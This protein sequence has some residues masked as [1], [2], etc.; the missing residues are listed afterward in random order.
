VTAILLDTHAFL[1]LQT[2]PE[3]LAPVLNILEDAETT[4][5]LSAVSSWEI[6]VKWELGKLELPE[7]PER[8]VPD[9][10]QRNGIEGLA[11]LHS[12]ALGVASLPR[13][14]RDP[15]DRMLIAQAL[16]EGIPLLTGD[17]AIRAYD[18]EVMWVG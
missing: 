11:V 8:F 14:H 7:P 5:L 3:K 18:V 6:A 4:L 13:H 16:A 1:W 10:M 9:R 12:H 15:F 17:D 2:T